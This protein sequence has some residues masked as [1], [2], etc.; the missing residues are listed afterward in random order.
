[1]IVNKELSVSGRKK[2][3]IVADLRK[4]N[5]RPFPK[6]KSKAPV[7]VDD[8]NEPPPDV[9]QEEE[10]SDTDFD[11]LLGMAIWSLT[12]EKVCLLSVLW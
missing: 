10:G 6:T 11:Y 8:N 7:T 2:A 1:M 5:F 3:A 9:E 4:H 12:R